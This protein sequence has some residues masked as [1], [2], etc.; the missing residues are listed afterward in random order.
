M[1]IYLCES[2]LC[3]IW[4]CN[5]LSLVPI[6]FF[7]FYP[8]WSLEFDPIRAVEHHSVFNVDTF[9][10]YRNFCQIQLRIREFEMVFFIIR[11]WYISELHFYFSHL[12]LLWTI[13]EDDFP[14]KYCKV[15]VE[16]REKKQELA[17]Y[18]W[19]LSGFI[20]KRISPVYESRM[21]NFYLLVVFFFL[22]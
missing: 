18:F 6:I 3:W 4:H 19:T 20:G 11:F 12:W 17:G 14:A 13:E 16:R 5:R 7:R 2:Q 8:S 22:L 9:M 1:H 10:S 21:S 15:F